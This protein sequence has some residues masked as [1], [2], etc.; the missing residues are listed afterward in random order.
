M[1]VT[2]IFIMANKKKPHQIK[3]FQFVLEKHNLT[4][5]VE[6]KDRHM[7]TLN[8]IITIKENEIYNIQIV[9]ECIL[10]HFDVFFSLKLIKIP[11]RKIFKFWQE[12]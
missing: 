6:N 2:S 10:G 4:N 1:V 12:L 5:L 9:D 7:D 11:K 3:E 8:L